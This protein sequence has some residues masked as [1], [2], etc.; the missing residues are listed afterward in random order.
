MPAAIRP[1]DAFGMVDIIAHHAAFTPHKLACR[2]LTSGLTLSYRGFDARIDRLAAL[3]EQ[4]L[5]DPAGQRVA[6][7]AYNCVDTLTLQHA[8]VRLGAIFVPLNWRLAPAE[9]K[10][11]AE[12]C[13]PALIVFD[14]AFAETAQALGV[15]QGLSL[16]EGFDAALAAAPQKPVRARRSHPDE[17]ST[18]LYTSGTTG[19]SKGVIITERNAF[20]SALHFS[21]NSQLNADSVF[22]CE[23]PLF[24]VAGLLA[25]GRGPFFQGGAILIGQRFEPELALKRIADPDLGVTHIF[26]VAQMTQTLRES[27]SFRPEIFRNIRAL[28]TGGAPNPAANIRRW[29]D[30]GVNMIDGFGMTEVGTA[31]AI[32]MGDLELI[33][34]KAGSA[35]LPSLLLRTRLVGDDG[36]EI[37][38]PGVPGEIRMKGPNVTP[39]YWKQPEATAKAFDEDGWFRSGDIATRDKDGFYYLVDRL[40]DMFVSGGENVYP[41]E[42]ENVIAELDAV[43]ESAV[44]AMPDDQWGEVG[45][46]YVVPVPGADVDPQAVIDHCRARLARYKAPK[47]VVIA[48]S[49]PRTASGKLQKNILRERLAKADA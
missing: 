2:D 46:A 45:L 8:C 26:Y 28:V 49:L 32:P 48:E 31:F 40:K 11:L 1:E 27:P 22:L 43:S 4:R 44:I 41:A 7:L 23:M 47:K 24:H 35:G 3:L 33:K 42:V 9:L 6:L 17:P 14:G 5:G 21:Q 39:G 12:D 30:A 20:A 10:V 25:A 19:R 37:N 16:D 15:D 29:A 18:L 34:A 36:Q 38:E 13:D